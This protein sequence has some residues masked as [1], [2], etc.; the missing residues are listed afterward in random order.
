MLRRDNAELALITD[1]PSTCDTSGVVNSMLT[2]ITTEEIILTTIIII[3]IIIIVVIVV[4]IEG[5]VN[6]HPSPS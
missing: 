5:L 4:D 3:I 1:A 6:S 2:Q